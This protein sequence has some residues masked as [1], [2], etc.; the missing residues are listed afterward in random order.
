MVTTLDEFGDL[1]RYNNYVRKT[2][3][4]GMARER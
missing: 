2:N 4:N 3:M 1:M